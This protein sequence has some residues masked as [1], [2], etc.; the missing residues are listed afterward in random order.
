[1]LGV[2]PVAGQ[3]Q[4]ALLAA[5]EGVFIVAGGVHI[6]L[7]DHPGDVVEGGDAG[8]AVQR[9]LGEHGV[10][11]H[12]VAAEAD[13]EGHV[14]VVQGGGVV[15]TQVH[16]VLHAAG[17]QLGQSILKLF[18]GPGV[19]VAG[20]HAHA[21]LFQHGLVGPQ[22]QAGVELR[23]GDHLAVVG[24]LGDDGLQ[25][26]ALQIV[27]DV[28]VDGLDHAGLIVA[29][30]QQVVGHDHVGGVAHHGRDLQLAVQLVLGIVLVV[31]GDA[32]LGLHLVEGLAVDI[33][34]RAGAHP[35]LDGGGAGSAAAGSLGNGTGGFIGSAAG[36]H[37]HR[38]GQRQ[39]AGHDPFH[40]F[41]HLD[42]SPFKATS[43]FF[44]SSD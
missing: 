4:R 20:G 42:T 17:L 44:R 27:A 15:L 6:A 38:H 34:L 26:V 18:L 29:G 30:D 16:G 39:S 1:M 22:S 31:D 23:G 24:G 25:Q 33:V 40:H 5:V 32:Q 3:G 21:S 9:A 35:H 19:G 43:V 13:H 36:R 41:L 28:L 11:V 10:A 8:F 7:V 14:G 2:H 12:V 37:Q